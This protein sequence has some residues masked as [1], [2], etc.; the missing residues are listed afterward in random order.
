MGE[1]YGRLRGIIVDAAAEEL[2]AEEPSG[3]EDAAWIGMEQQ[4]PVALGPVSSIA[5]FPLHLPCFLSVDLDHVM[6]LALPFYPCEDSSLH[7]FGRQWQSSYCCFE[8]ICGGFDIS[9]VVLVYLIV[10][11]WVF[12]SL[13]FFG[14]DSQLKKADFVCGILV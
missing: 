13:D 3:G 2:A 4:L 1:D 11:M 6:V 8:W 7:W 5:I 14:F 9:I 10:H 12:N